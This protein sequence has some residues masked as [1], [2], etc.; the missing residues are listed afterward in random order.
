MI[1]NDLVQN[2]LFSL[3][4][5]APAGVANSAPIVASKIPWLKKLNYPADFG[6]SWKG[7]RV[8]G[9]HKTIRG[10]VAGIVTAILSVYIT[11]AAYNQYQFVRD[12]SFLDYNEVNLLLLGFLLGAG[13]LIGDSVKSFFKR[14]V[15]LQPGKSW[16]PFDQ[17]DF[18]IGMSLFSAIYIRFD[19]FFYIVT[20][21]L[22]F[23]MHVSS[24]VLGYLVKLK[25]SPI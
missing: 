23:S 5:F 17:I 6:F 2:I 8:L 3:L 24:T 13:A 25:D 1:E 14:R 9:D 22:W 19:L 16:L 20:L 15:D 7:K 11:R 4:F 18:I 21:V 10:F 12:N